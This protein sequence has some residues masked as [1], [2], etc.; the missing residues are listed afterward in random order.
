L[1]AFVDWT[2]MR[3][4]VA[5]VLVFAVAMAESLAVVGLAVPGAAMIIAAGAL[6]ALGA[7]AFWPTLLFAI[8]SAIVGD[9]V[10]FWIGRRYRGELRNVWPFRRYPE[11]LARG[12]EFFHRHGGKTIFFG[13]FIGPIRPLIPVVA[14]CSTCTPR[15]SMR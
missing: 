8:A 2:A 15:L 4:A 9:G 11:W 10:S 7:L 13:R 3:P 1:Q 12:E 14:A 5:G 6:V